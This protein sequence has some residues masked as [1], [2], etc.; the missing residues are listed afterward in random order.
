MLVT[1]GDGARRRVSA[2]AEWALASGCSS[3]VRPLYW[4][5]GSSR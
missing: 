2:S 1:A 3:S 4:M 5:L